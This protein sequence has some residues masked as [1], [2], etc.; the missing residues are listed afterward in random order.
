MTFGNRFSIHNNRV[1]KA[2]QKN[3]PRCSGTGRVSERGNRIVCRVCAGAG[4][5]EAATEKRAS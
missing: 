2:V 4:K 1:A 3:C 5:V